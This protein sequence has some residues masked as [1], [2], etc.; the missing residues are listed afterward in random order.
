MLR[1]QLPAWNSGKGILNLHKSAMLP[2]VVLFSPGSVCPALYHRA[3][4]ARD[5]LGRIWTDRHPG[6][7]GSTSPDVQLV[8]VSAVE[9]NCML[10]FVVSLLQFSASVG[11]RCSQHYASLG[12][13]S[14]LASKP[15][16]KLHNFNFGEMQFVSTYPASLPVSAS[17]LVLC[18]LFPAL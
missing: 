16:I 1:R 8:K 14:D 15:S 18:I 2:L 13:G 17:L 11:R 5:R 7:Q 4:G 6:K 3:R 10:F 9:E 12:H